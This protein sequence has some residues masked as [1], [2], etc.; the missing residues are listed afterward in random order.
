[1]PAD[2]ELSRILNRRNEIN[3]A[4]DNGETVKVSVVIRCRESILSLTRPT[5]RRDLS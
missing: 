2:N 3:D 5:R 1:M 4:I